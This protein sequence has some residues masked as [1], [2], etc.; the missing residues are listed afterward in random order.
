MVICGKYILNADE[1]KGT[2]EDLAFL[3]E[4]AI[5]ANQADLD[6]GVGSQKTEGTVKARMYFADGTDAEVKLVQVRRRQ[7][8]S[9]YLLIPSW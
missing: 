5:K 3:D 1:T 8:D 2:L 9:G 6:K 7:A 4:I